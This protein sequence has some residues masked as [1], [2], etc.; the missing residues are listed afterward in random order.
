MNKKRASGT[1]NRSNTKIPIKLFSLLVLSIFL[2]GCG[3]TGE[4]NHKFKNWKNTVKY[5]IWRDPLVMRS[6]MKVV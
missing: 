3:V 5:E 4:K 2:K 6:D 1:R